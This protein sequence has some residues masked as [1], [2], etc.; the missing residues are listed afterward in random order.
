[1]ARAAGSTAR[2]MG[3]R[4]RRSAGGPGGW[5]GRDAA[6]PTSWHQLVEAALRAHPDMREVDLPWNG[7]KA[8]RIAYTGPAT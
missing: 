7:E 8:L 4:A 1:M 5:I 2:R 6:K 3:C